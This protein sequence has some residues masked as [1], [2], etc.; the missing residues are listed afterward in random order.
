MGIDFTTSKENYSS[1]SERKIPTGFGNILLCLFL[2]SISL[3]KFCLAPC[4]VLDSIATEP[5]RK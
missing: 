1:L 3:Q 2:F 4:Q 5:N